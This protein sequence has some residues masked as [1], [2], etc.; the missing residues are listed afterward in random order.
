MKYEV[1]RTFYKVRDVK[2]RDENFKSTGETYPVYSNL[3]K[4]YENNKLIKEFT[5][6]ALNDKPEFN[7]SQDKIVVVYFNSMNEAVEFKCLKN[8]KAAARQVW[9]NYIIL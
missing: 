2:V 1:K 7:K 3:F 5:A 6:T 4:L 8:E 9:D